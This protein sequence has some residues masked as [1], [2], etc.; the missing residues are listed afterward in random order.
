MMAGNESELGTAS[1][2]PV[3]RPRPVDR[4]V[5][6]GKIPAV[7]VHRIDEVQNAE[8]KDCC[9]QRLLHHSLPRWQTGPFS[10]SDNDGKFL[11]LRAF[12]QIPGRIRLKFSSSRARRPS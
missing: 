3:Q 10:A 8:A 7:E 2:P 11:K 5:G 1:A 9:N 6:R 4:L 12:G